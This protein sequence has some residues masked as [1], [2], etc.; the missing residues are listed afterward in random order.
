[1]DAKPSFKDPRYIISIFLAE[2]KPEKVYDIDADVV[3]LVDSSRGVGAENFEKEKEFV[4]NAAHSLNLA[5]GRS[6]VAVIPYSSYA[7]Q[8]I[9]FGDH[10]TMRTFIEDVDKLS[11][12]G[13]SRRIDRALNA[14]ETLLKNAPSAR[15]KAVILLTA[16]KQDSGFGDSLT[17]AAATLHAMRVKT[18]V[19]AIG[20]A[21]DVQE[22]RPVANSQ[23]F[24]VSS[25]AVLE[26]R[27]RPIVKHVAENI[28]ENVS[29]KVF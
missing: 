25:F 2:P 5:P 3:I 20:R 17:S 18:Y 24:A 13:N 10:S 19:I 15:P 22:L 12:V 21:P 11:I 1:M 6:R 14:A 28:G 16:G 29:A 9:E 8:P 23:L 27:T 7:R 4:K 26:H